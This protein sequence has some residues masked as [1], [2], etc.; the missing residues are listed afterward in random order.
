MRRARVVVAVALAMAGLLIG[1]A[2]IWQGQAG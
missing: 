1:G 2:M